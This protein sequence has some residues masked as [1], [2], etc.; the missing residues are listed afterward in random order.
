M[1]AQVKASNAASYLVVCYSC[2]RAHLKPNR[3]VRICP[4]KLA[5]CARQCRLQE[6]LEE[7]LATPFGSYEVTIKKLMSVEICSSS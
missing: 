1:I 3:T 6:L 5:P 4:P 7:D 2:L